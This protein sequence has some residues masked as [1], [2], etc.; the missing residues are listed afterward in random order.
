[1]GR[2]GFLRAA[3][4]AGMAASQVRGSSAELGNHG[5]ITDVGGIRVGHFTDSRRPTGCTVVIFDKPAVAGVDVRGSAPGT[6]ETDLLRPVNTVQQVNAILLT[7]GSAFGLDAAT[8]VMRY[9]EEHGMG[10]PVGVGVVPIV[11]AAVLFDLSI[12][13]PKIRPDAR[14]G[15]AACEAA[16]SSN[17]REG[18]FG[19]GAGATVGKLFG[20]THAMKGGIGTASIK[21]GDSGL[22][23]GA[24]VAVNAMGD[25]IDRIA[26]TIL[27]GARS[28]DGQGFVNSM[29]QIMQ[30]NLGV[31]PIGENS[32]IGLVATNASLNKTE[33]TKVAQMAHDGLARAINPVHTAF[34]G[35][36]IFAAATGASSRK[37]DHTMIGAI[38]AE[39]M[40]RAV[41][42]AVITTVGLPGYPAYQDFAH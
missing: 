9:L 8:G 29:N 6:R 16:S 20:M 3:S 13:D 42:R 19:A 35:D 11:P 40:A 34:D 33:M 5:C 41:N 12:G 1:M 22:M 37:A 32:T 28:P 39:V 25:I 38:A 31:S 30:G 36:T 7:G 14:S 2:R 27:A 24:I 23:V 26:G 17:V 10:F 18:S 15:Y 4:L 21:I